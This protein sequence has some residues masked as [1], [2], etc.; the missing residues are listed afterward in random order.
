MS[1]QIKVILN[2]D[3]PSL[4]IA[5]ETVSVSGGYARNFLIKEG[6]AQLWTPKAELKIRA[7]AAK[8]DAQKLED[9]ERA[10]QL[11]EALDGIV[12]V[13]PAKVSGGGKLFGGI[14]PEMISSALK[15]KGIALDPRA[16][17]HESIK[18][19]G[20]HKVEACLHPQINA[21][22]TVAVTEK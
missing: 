17:R 20:R 18:Q 11:K 5:G 9:R 4:G 14:T 16:L 19:I 7:A 10:A 21:T 15:E 22:F 8:K 2:K 3:V 12:V 1:K 13:I 6:S